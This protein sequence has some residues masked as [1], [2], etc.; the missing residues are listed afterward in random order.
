MAGGLRKGVLTMR[1]E[2]GGNSTG[3]RPLEKLAV[4]HVQASM[5]RTVV[6][7]EFYDR[8]VKDVAV[9][10][11]GCLLVRRTKRG[12]MVGRIVETEAYLAAGDPACHAARGMTKRNRPM[13]GPPGWAYVYSIHARWCLNAVCQ[14]RSEPAAVLIRAVEPFFGIEQIT[15]HRGGCR[16][17]D[18]ARGPS[19]LCEALQVDQ[20]FN[21]THL[22]NPNRLWIAK[23]MPHAANQTRPRIASSPRIGVSSAEDLRLRFFYDGCRFVSGPR[24]WHT[25]PCQ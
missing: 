6:P 19:R 9:E 15:D 5:R 3:H 12:L 8:N 13:F 22:T 7:S 11:L 2:N 18:L 20:R 4:H 17:L 24:K 10:L 23:A 21:E 25:R 16:A 14:S 1:A